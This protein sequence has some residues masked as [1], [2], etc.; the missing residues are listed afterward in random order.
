MTAADSSS[1]G[2]LA[3]RPAAKLIAQLVNGGKAT[4]YLLHFP[5]PPV[6][7]LPYSGPAKLVLGSGDVVDLGS[8]TAPS[9]ATWS[10]ARVRTLAEDVPA[11]Q[12]G[13][14]ATLVWGPAMFVAEV[15][16]EV[17]D[18]EEQAVQAAAALLDTQPVADSALSVEVT[19]QV[20]ELP[21][22]H[23][24]YVDGG[25]DNQLLWTP[26][27]GKAEDGLGYTARWVFGYP[28]PGQYAV[29]VNLIDGDGYFVMQL[30]E[31]EL[32][33]APP[34]EEPPTEKPAAAVQ[35]DQAHPGEDSGAGAVAEDEV[36]A[37]ASAL[38]PWLP[39]RYARPMWAWAR[40]YTQA[41]GSV[42]SR[43]LALGTYLAI[44][45]EVVTGGQLWYQTGS[46]DWIPASSVALIEVSELRGVV[47]S[48]V[49]PDPEPEPE[50]GP[51]PDPD[52]LPRGT[53]IADVL[54]VRSGPGVQ[55]PVVDQ[56]RYGAQVVIYTQRV[57]DGA[58][59]YR[60]GVNRWVHGGWIRLSTTPQPD[61]D[62]TRRGVVTAHVLNVRARP[63]VRADNPP[64]D[65]LLRGTQ[66]IIYD[67][68]VVLGATWYR[69]GVDRWVHSGWVQL[70]NAAD[71]PAWMNLDGPPD[72][73][74]LDSPSALPVG[75][76]VTSSLNVRAEPSTSSK[77]VGTVYHNEA[78]PILETT[79]VGGQRW[80]RIGAGQW[81]YGANVGVA[82]IKARPAAIRSDERWVGVNLREQTVVAY[83][84]DKPVYAAL[85]AT[86]LPLTPTV[87]GVF[88][89][90]WR[91]VSRKMAGGSPATGGYYYLEEVPWTCYFYSGYALHAA[92]WHDAFGRPRSHGCVNLSPYD[93]WWIFKWS[94][95]GGP[96]SPAVY[97]YW[98]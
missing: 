96:N 81:V 20:G 12:D 57:V 66:V 48:G 98:E 30:A 49:D 95:A 44:R 27:G 55:N 3:P 87:Q 79:T 74:K 45:Q 63:G 35:P 28:K 13:D 59:W 73:F 11:D 85:A 93:A 5:A 89:T 76:V 32:D 77:I 94:E 41:G 24:V 7:A 75:W 14:E 40:T 17:V 58:T 88:R 80:L 23:R 46:Y 69:I 62:E 37:S 29:T 53:V 6:D 60:I 97:V 18:G 43:Y 50:P 26:S 8:L 67:E 68:A 47:L 51:E 71:D 39:F 90:W 65:R 42:V 84:G 38:P 86:G 10:S 91:L 34:I 70:V 16:D 33:I 9:P 2:D 54:N 78:L 25:G 31:V 52:E 61:P 92:Y 4:T 72:M 56:L 1:P 83:E 22:G 21:P 36:S 15:V 82:R 64:V 19:L